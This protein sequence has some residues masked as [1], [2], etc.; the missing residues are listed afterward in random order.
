MS[1]SEAMLTLNGREMHVDPSSEMIERYER[2]CAA[3]ANRAAG[4]NQSQVLREPPASLA[5][6]ISMLR[7]HNPLIQGDVMIVDLERICA[8]QPTI[9][10]TQA[11][12]YWTLLEFARPSHNLRQ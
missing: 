12:N 8:A 3:V 2:A 1:H 9:L 10:V 11:A 6:H 4:V 5:G 7:Q